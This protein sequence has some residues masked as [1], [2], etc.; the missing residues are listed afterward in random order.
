MLLVSFALQLLKQTTLGFSILAKMMIT[1]YNL[2]QV[3]KMYMTKQ[4][5]LE[6]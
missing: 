5:P 4:Y 3:R 2:F 1:L 6:S